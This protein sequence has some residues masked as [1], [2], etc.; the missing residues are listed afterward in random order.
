MPDVIHPASLAP[1]RGYSNGLLFPAN[2][3]VLFVAGQIGWDR[4]GRF[5]SD[6]LAAQFDLALANV[7]DVV[8]EAGG[9]PEH[10]GRLTI[11]V[12]DKHEYIAA[13]KTIGAS[14]RARMGKHYPAMALV[15]VAALLEDRAKVEIEATAVIP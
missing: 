4:E 14:Y 2:G 1:P 9:A 7:L 10:V 12:T 13:A 6:E 15:Q 8:R 11:Y 3:R 5:P